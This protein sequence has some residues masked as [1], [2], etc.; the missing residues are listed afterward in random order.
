MIV[1]RGWSEN[2]PVF[3]KKCFNKLISKFLDEMIN[4]MCK[5]IFELTSIWP[6]HL[7]KLKQKRV[8]M[9]E[10]M[11]ESYNA[12]TQNNGWFHENVTIYGA[13]MKFTLTNIAKKN[14]C[15]N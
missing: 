14:I 1:W 2:Y 11:C 9:K 6:A 12:I 13:K 8:T 15:Q 4:V 5:S 7:V 3:M 10:G